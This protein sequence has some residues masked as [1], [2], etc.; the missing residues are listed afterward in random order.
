MWILISLFVL[1]LLALTYMLVHRAWQIQSGKVSYSS[2]DAQERS[3]LPQVTF[4]AVKK[5]VL[6]YGRRG[7]HFF[8][9]TVLHAWVI[10]SHAVIKKWSTWF[11]KKTAPEGEVQ[12]P[13]PIATFVSEYKTRAKRIRDRVKRKEKQKEILTTLQENTVIEE[14]GEPK[15]M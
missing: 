6:Y 9:M 11:P 4:G 8:I 5:N 1:F 13:S 12:G 3:I 10:I 15:E 14:V 7:L 2:E